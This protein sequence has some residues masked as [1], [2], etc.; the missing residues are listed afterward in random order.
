MSLYFFV[1]LNTF[2]LPLLDFDEKEQKVPSLEFPVI[3]S[4]NA[5]E[6]DSAVED[7]DIVAESVSLI[8]EEQKFTIQAEGDLNKAKIEMPAADDLT[9]KITGAERKILSK[10]SIE[11]LKK[12]IPASKIS[13]QVTIEFNKDYPLKLTYTEIDKVQLTFILAPRVEND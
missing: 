1:L 2:S 11:Y 10:Y 3:V 7:A 9:I 8:A 6:L 12:M 5:S 13:G 4:L